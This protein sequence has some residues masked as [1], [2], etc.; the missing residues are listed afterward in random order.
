MGRDAPR[1][2]IEGRIVERPDGLVEVD[3]PAHWTDAR[4]EA[5]LD[6]AG[7]RVDL[8]A[9][10]V[11]YSEAL[12]ARAQA[13]GLVKD[14]RARRRFREGLTEALLLGAVAIVD[15]TRRTLRVIDAAAPD[16]VPA[17]Q[18][19]EAAHRGR[20]AAQAAAERLSARLQA[21][22]DAIL[23][24][25]GDAEACADP[26]RNS[27]LARAAEAARAAGA[28]DAAILDAVALARSG[29]S[30]WPAP[31]S[32]IAPTGPDLICRIGDADPPEMRALARA[33]W[34]TGAV[35]AVRERADGEALAGL[36]AWPRGGVDLM[37]F[38]GEAGFD[39]DAFE[40]AVHLAAVALAA[41]DEPG[42]LGLAGL[43]DWLVARGQDYGS[44]E[45]RAAA[46]DLYAAA[47][48]VIGEAGVECRL[49][50]FDDPELALRLGG[51]LDAAPWNGPV[52]LAETAE[53]EILRVLS[54][55]ALRGLDA[56]ALDRA[57][58]EAVL[59][60]R[61]SLGEAPGVNVQSLAARGFSEH[62][63]AAAEAELP[64][65]ARL[66]EAFAPRILGDGF[67]RDVLGATPEQ[68][69]DP[70]LDVLALAGFACDDALAA[71]T[72][73]LGADTLTGS[74]VGTEAQQRHLRPAAELSVA[75]KVE[76]LSVLRPALDAPPVVETALPWRATPAD[77]QAALSASRLPLRLRR[78]AA[79][80]DAVLELPSV[81]D[82]PE[83]REPPPQA[84]GAPEERIV[85]RIVERDRTRRKLPDRRKGY[86]QKAS[87]GG[88]KV[89]IHTGEYDDG[90]LGEI[91]IDMHKEGAAFR[92]LM[93]NFAIAISIGL[94]YGVPLEE[95]VDAFVFTRFEPAGPVTGNDTVKSATS[96]L[97]Y[98]F[99][100]LG[101]SY[102]GRS[103]LASED[104]GALN[105]DGLG[106]GKADAGH[107]SAGDAEPAP[108]PASRFISRGFSRGSTPD[109]LVFLPTANRNPGPAVLEAAEVCA[110]CGDIAVVRKGQAMICE[111]CGARA[112]RF[113]EDQTG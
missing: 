28:S 22:M 46:H 83:R 12:T 79:P 81:A 29:E 14:L 48:R 95:F 31:P 11:E 10:I 92:S 52:T 43:G 8:A 47:R 51:R 21:V 27:S 76:M 62:E 44:D 16:F 68:L 100:E 63:I 69:T 90:E 20:E 109:N 17:L 78:E 41:T 86:I 94:Q 107:D 3:A 35:I 85:E 30:L 9:A 80:A 2:G 19:L 99:R 67:L 40:G 97:D 104:P 75:A 112:G 33:A 15:G 70:A 18:A 7:G 26:T 71:E 54:D 65:V 60:G 108:Q 87:V 113:G 106:N 49:G 39:W 53:G 102:L 5:W 82:L 50:A 74:G 103:D 93:N 73:A 37:A 4:V 13:K 45:G 98:I 56:L 57:A 24:C 55:A 88:H 38:F 91:F 36:A 89:Y 34:T 6:W 96:I 59:L 1:V 32:N 58:A 105:A 42:L 72:Y 110:A 25:E 111:T 77:F 101:I 61:R 64:F 23:R 66:A 84:A